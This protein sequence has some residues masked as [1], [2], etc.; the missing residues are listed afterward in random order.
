MPICFH[1]VNL[2]RIT[3]LELSVVQNE[4]FNHQ[5]EAEHEH[6]FY[7]LIFVQSGSGLHFYRE[8]RYEISAGDIFLILPGQTHSYQSMEALTIAN[9]IFQPSIL[10][11][12]FEEFNKL[13]GFQN[14]FNPDPVFLLEQEPPPKLRI[15][16][17]LI[18]DAIVLIET[19]QYELEKN[20]EGA[21]I[22]VTQ[23]F[24]EFL[25][26]ISRNCSWSAND[27]ILYS[28]KINQ[29]LSFMKSHLREKITL[30]DLAG[31]IDMSTDHFRKL[32][33]SVL[34]ESPISYLL[35]LRLR[36][37]AVLL[38]ST[39]KNISEVAYEAGFNDSNYFAHQFHKYYRLS[40][41]KYRHEREGNFF[42]GTTA[43]H[44][45]RTLIDKRTRK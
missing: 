31:H 24:I 21:K 32:F 28:P 18:P 42:I 6:D 38:R 20:Q 11:P 14:I 1:F 5:F 41:L 25:L 34:K 15:P 3:D 44:G 17:N 4:Y 23:K 39:S 43:Y 33:K 37:A 19:M 2:A 26:L 36:A 13:S 29:V 9:L 8:H 7:E 40:P 35:K 30:D 10:A 16:E 22:A 27:D 45:Q 12:Y